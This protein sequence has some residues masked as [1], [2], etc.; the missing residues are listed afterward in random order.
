MNLATLKFQRIR[1]TKV[2]KTGRPDLAVIPAGARLEMIQAKTPAD[3][4]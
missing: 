1:K 2:V 3:A 4:L